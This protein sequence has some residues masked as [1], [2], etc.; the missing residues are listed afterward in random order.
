MLSGVSVSSDVPHPDV[1]SS[2]SQQV[3][4][5]LIGQ[6]GQPVGTGAQYSMLEE[7]HWTLCVGGVCVC[8]CMYACV[9]VCV[10]VCMRVCVCVGVITYNV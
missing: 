10:C 4:E 3:G 9:C 6:V 8:A 2:V 7:E 1:E 5:A